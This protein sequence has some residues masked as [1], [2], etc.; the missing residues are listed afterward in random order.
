MDQE[1]TAP[2]PDAPAA[3]PLPDATPEAA[4]APDPVASDAT[5]TEK[6]DKPKKPRAKR[7]P[8]LKDWIR[9]QKSGG[10]ACKNHTI[11]LIINKATNTCTLA[12]NAS[13]TE[14]EKGNQI[15]EDME[16]ERRQIFKITGYEIVDI[17]EAKPEPEPTPAATPAS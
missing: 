14:D 8:G 9:V 13:A 3:A 1:N 15:G 6:P 17:P 11:H 10:N 4:P 2:A 16:G 12:T 7:A 5:T